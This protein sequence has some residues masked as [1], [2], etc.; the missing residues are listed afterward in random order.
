MTLSDTNLR[1]EKNSNAF[2]LLHAYPILA[3][4]HVTNIIQTTGPSIR[5]VPLV[6]LKL[7]YRQSKAKSFP[8]NIKSRDVEV[9]VIKIKFESVDRCENTS[10]N[11]TFHT[12]VIL[13]SR[14]SQMTSTNEYKFQTVVTIPLTDE[15]RDNQTI[16]EEHAGAAVAAMYRDGIVVLENAVNVEHVDKLNQILTSEA[17]T[18][19]TLSTTH[20]NNVCIVD[21]IDIESYV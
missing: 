11:L 19:A 8:A 10:R 14:H 15:E 13:H 20:F 12:E 9:Y 1:G 4:Y 18:L 16:N 21:H 7:R 5:E 3:Y 17:E 6:E 2:L